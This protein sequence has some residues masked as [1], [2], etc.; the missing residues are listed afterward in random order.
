MFVWNPGDINAEQESAIIAPG[1]VFLT[2]CPG[3]GKTRT[4]TYKIAYELARLSSDKQRVVAITY[5]NRAA[6]EIRDRIESLG[7]DTQHLWIGTLHSFCLEWIL[8]PYAIYHPLLA[9]GFG[10]I[11]PHDAETILEE[12]LRAQN[13]GVTIYDCNYFYTSQELKISCDPH[14][15]NYVADIVGQYQARLAER[16]LIDFELI[17]KCAFELIESQ[18][19]IPKILSSIFS[20]ILVDEYQ[21]TKEIQYVIL[22]KILRAGDGQ[23]RSFVVGDPNQAIYGSLGGYS[24][25]PEDFANLTGLTLDLRALSGNYRSSARI[26]AYFENYNLHRTPILAVGHDRNFQSLITYDTLTTQA[27]LLDQITRLVIHSIEVAGIPQ[28]EMCIL[29]PQWM[30]LASLTR[31]LIAAMPQYEFDGPGMV[32][33]SRDPENFWY[34]LSRIGLTR[35]SPRMYVRRLRWAHEV[36]QDLNNAGAST[37]EITAKM[38]LRAS[39]TFHS[40]QNDGLRYLSEY[41]DAMLAFLEINYR[42]FQTLSDHHQAFF[43]S[44]QARIERI[45]QQGAESIRD[46]TTFKKVFAERSGITIST[47]HGVKGGEFDVVI[48]YGLLQGMVPHFN[49]PEQ[50]ESAAKL[51]YVTCSRAR[52]H[53]HLVSERERPR[54]RYSTYDPTTILAN[55]QFN[56]DQI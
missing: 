12:L 47:I 9:Q 34:K 41:F 33:F 1:N 29:A 48:A 31:R 43:E 10:V 14:K 19:S 15:R 44:S 30:P 26:V 52:K 11:S 28:H 3:S 22:G 32:P 56:Y 18:P 37:S 39:N 38:L 7:V 17:L 16:R 5:T 24:I 45:A 25:R 40:L 55:T 49:D 4:L 46:I 50:Y 13:R 51:L 23:V 8:R 20:I 35:P 27:N 36:L 6:D 53:L 54:G 2:A 21:D 42:Q